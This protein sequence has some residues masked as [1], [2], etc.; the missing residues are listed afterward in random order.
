MSKSPRGWVRGTVL[1]QLHEVPVTDKRSGQSMTLG[2]ASAQVGL[3]FGRLALVRI[4][5]PTNLDWATGMRWGIVVVATQRLIAAATRPLEA[6]RMIHRMCQTVYRPPAAPTPA[7]PTPP[8]P[9]PSASTIDEIFL[10]LECGRCSNYRLCR[11]LRPLGA[12]LPP[13]TPLCEDCNA[14]C[15]PSSAQ[16]LIISDRYAAAAASIDGAE[17]VE[18][19]WRIAVGT[20]LID[21]ALHDLGIAQ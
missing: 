15:T 18:R 10:L 7:A 1:V 16:R 4:T 17:T 20:I 21:H 2:A 12:P 19:A 14:R 11:S 8:A 9:T 6:V 13:T 5:A 3:I